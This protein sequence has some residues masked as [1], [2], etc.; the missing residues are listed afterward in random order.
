MTLLL[1]SGRPPARL[2]LLLLAVW[3]HIQQHQN[4]VLAW[5]RG[6]TGKMTTYHSRSSLSRQHRHDRYH[7]SLLRQEPSFASRATHLVMKGGRTPSFDD[8]DFFD[9]DFAQFTRDM[10]EDRISRTISVDGT[11]QARILSRRVD[12][13][14]NFSIIVWEWEKPAAV[15]ETYWQ[16]QQ[17]GLALTKQKLRKNATSQSQILDPFGLVTWPGSVIA[18]QE[19]LLQQNDLLPTR[20]ALVRNK[21]VL[22]LGAGVGVEAQAAAR[23]GARQVIA[24]DI[25]PTTLQ[26]LDYGAKQAGPDC[27]SRISTRVLDLSNHKHQPLPDCDLMI[28]A[29]VLYNDELAHHVIQRCVEARQKR[30]PP[31]ILVSD[32]QR[33]VH[34]FERDL[35]ERLAHDI[36]GHARVAWMSRRLPQFTGSGVCIDADQTYD[37]K[38]RVMWIGLL[39]QQQQQ[40]QS[41]NMSTVEE[42]AEDR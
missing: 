6:M 42:D 36:A 33:F 27:Q 32:S 34:S 26:L 25:H 23:L 3:Y 37:V 24:T 39:E 19:L 30:H 1:L 16:V 31:V 35:N 7:P 38:A 17:Q 14:N 5:T 13:A 10:P 18:V 15:V 9:E 11:K 8:I 29:D 2:R 41:W 4:V 12:I 21:T 40:Q 20:L 22:V 28:I